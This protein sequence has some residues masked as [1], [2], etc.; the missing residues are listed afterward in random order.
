MDRPQIKT[1]SGKKI[2][3]KIKI[4]GQETVWYNE[5][6]EIEPDD[7]KFE[8][9]QYDIIFTDID[10]ENPIQVI[11]GQIKHKYESRGV[12]YYPVYFLNKKNV[13]SQIGVLEV[14]KDEV[15]NIYE[16]GELIP[17][18]SM[19]L[20]YS[21][22]NKKYLESL[23]QSMDK[24]KYEER[25][26]EEENEEGESEENLSSD[27]EDSLFRVKTKSKV[28]TVSKKSI[29]SADIHK[30]Q[31][32]TLPE[33]TKED[34]T[35]N[36]KTYNLAPS[37]DWIVKLM[38]NNSYKIHDTNNCLFDV[39]V[40]AFSE[41]GE[42]ITV[43]QLRELLAEEVTEEIFEN[44]CKLR[45]EYDN[46]QNETERTLESS[47][48]TLNLLKKRIKT[49]D[50]TVDEKR[51]IIEE[52]KKTKQ[53]I[54][55]L[56]Q[57]SRDYAS[58]VKRNL[59]PNFNELQGVTDLEK[60][61]SFVRSH[62]YC[63][64]RWSIIALEHLLN[65]K[66]IVLSEDA[67]K[68][69]AYDSVLDC[70]KDYER[71]FAPN[72]YIIVSLARYRYNI[73]SYKDKKLLMYREIPYDIKMMIINKCM[74]MNAGN[75]NYIQEFRNLKSRMGIPLD[76]VEAEDDRDYGVE[77]DRDVVFNFN[78]ASQ[79]K[80]MPGLGCGENIPNDK[81]FE[82]IPLADIPEWRNKLDDSWMA[83][84]TMDRR[85]WISVDNSIEGSKY[86]KTYPDFAIMFSL[87]SDSPISKNP[88][89]AKIVGGKGKH[90]L[91][92]PNVKPDSDYF[93][94]R[95]VTTRH[96]ALVAKFEQNLDLRNTL[97]A[98]KNATLK[99]FERGKK[100]IVR[101]DLMRV[102]DYLAGKS[103]R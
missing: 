13:A 54:A 74:E 6:T 8:S 7:E 96:N 89:L 47:R 63:A 41:I 10:K 21:F 98:T 99:Q 77:Y 38:K 87:D 11:F 61:K 19:I 48:R 101:Y 83:P 43:D 15:L 66:F 1:Q 79:D 39:I 73:V 50:I 16:D 53:T 80:T 102:R 67:Y 59:S 37:D 9:F 68:D 36:R 28:K 52:A 49:S 33:E 46:I 64:E 30:K 70:G 72:F 88:T 76:E 45:I 71:T 100:P 14:T 82:Y 4:K 65:V 42:Q 17:D 25:D 62:K 78:S 29:F 60:Y 18:V 85:R 94:E 81:I 27:S 93:A 24:L 95:S 103:M 51:R 12:L 92:P 20:L 3:S 44:E 34:A 91:K 55:D 5:T 97:L 26:E 58:F 23:D 90:E 86:S 32:A 2:Q 69:Q 75:Y 56:S 22:V 84:F 31:I 40:K 35:A 57:Q